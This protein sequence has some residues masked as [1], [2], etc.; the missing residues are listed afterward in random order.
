MVTNSGYVNYAATY[1][2]KSEGR[3]VQVEASATNDTAGIREI[4][5]IVQDK[6]GGEVPED[7]TFVNKS[8]NG[9]FKSFQAARKM[10]DLGIDA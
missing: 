9:I 8:V 3:Q 2:S 10:A 7:L 4:V 5:A 1:L 6:E